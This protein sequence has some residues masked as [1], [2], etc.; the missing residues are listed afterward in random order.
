M[1]FKEIKHLYHRIGFGLPLNQR[2]DYTMFYSLSREQVI[3][4]LLEQSKTAVPLT[5]DLGMISSY[6]NSTNKPNK[7]AL[8]NLLQSS[9]HKLKEMNHKWIM[10]LASGEALLR[11]KM[12]LFW[13][14]H[15]VCKDT[16]IVHALAY[17]NTLR[18]HAL[19]DF[20][21]LLTAV[22]KS[23]AMIKYLNLKQNK[24]AQPNENFS[25]ELMELFTLGTG[26]YSER[27]I[28]EAARAFTG[29]N[30]DMTGNFKM[31]KSQ[32]DQGEKVFF[33]HSGNYGG[34]AIIA[35]IL[36]QQQCARF[37][38]EKIYR[39]FV[40]DTLHPTHVDAMTAVFF[41]DYNIENLMRF[42]L[43]SDWFYDPKN[44]GVKIKSP[45]ELLVGIQH[46]IPLQFHQTKE[47]I[48]L[49]G[50][51][52][53]VLLYPPNVAGW[54]GGKSW[55]DANTMML[56]LKLPAMLLNKGVIYWDQKEDVAASFDRFNSRKNRER[57][58][59]ISADWTC[60][61]DY[62]SERSPS[63]IAA[64]V[65]AAETSPKMEAFLANLDK[66]D[67]RSYCI[68]LMSLPEYQLC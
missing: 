43:E 60:F 56:R 49:Q 17:N 23:A 55:I 18:E 53:Q 67:L 4:K 3:V 1:T 52:G 15:F 42:V 9:R 66:T 31:R 65:I 61:L 47:L 36:E 57:I 19:G 29:W 46:T 51:M 37:I 21:T 7:Q 63:T 25:R 35:I 6:M 50:L 30:H 22:S 2:K 38:C 62:Y 27:D 48:Y 59:Q 32:H 8:Q 12:T 20:G 28:K 40:N 16:N 45:I 10:R 54:P 33:G 24:K 58:L 64:Q 34:E 13:A 5:M 39:Y 14:N 11:E 26:Q 68:Q 44:I 41:N